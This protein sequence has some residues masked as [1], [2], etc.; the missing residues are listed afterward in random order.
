MSY[1]ILI[2]RHAQKELARLP[3]DVFEQIRD[4]IRALAQ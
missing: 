3:I 1:T 4:A 2:L